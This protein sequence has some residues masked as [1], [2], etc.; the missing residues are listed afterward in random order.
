MQ[1][2][3]GKVK[4]GLVAKAIKLSKSS[5]PNQCQVIKAKSNIGIKHKKLW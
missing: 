4:K 3:G 5:I 1:L 2:R